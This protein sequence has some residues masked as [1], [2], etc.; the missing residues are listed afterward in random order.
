MAFAAIDYT[1]AP[2]ASVHA[3]SLECRKALCWL[4]KH[5][6]ELGFD[7]QRIVVAG[8]S[9]GAHLAAMCCLRGW[10]DNPDLPVGVP[11]AAVL[12]SGIYDLQPLL[13]T[14]I[15]EALSLD[16][17]SAQAISPQ[18]LALAGFPPAVVCWGE[19]ETLEFKRQSK[20]FA[21]ALSA[22]GAQYLP[23]IEVPARNHFDVIL[24]LARPGTPLGDATRALFSSLSATPF[25]SK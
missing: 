3:I 16:S 24:D 19:I 11:A 25:R 8:S 6:T 4:H 7:P 14:S 18:L 2:R 9:A 22:V 21:N 5:G 12:V 17:A 20:S 23:C 1:L 10:K 15:N 13:G